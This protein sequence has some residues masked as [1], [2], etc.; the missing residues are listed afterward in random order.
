[1]LLVAEFLERWRANPPSNLK[2]RYGNPTDAQIT[3]AIKDQARRLFA[4]TVEFRPP[5]VSLNFKGITFEDMNDPGFLDTLHK[6][7]TRTGISQEV[8]AKLFE[9]GAVAASAKS[10]KAG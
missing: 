7:M 3:S 8:I 2:R 5:E 9:T 6:V 1:M 10:F 4:D